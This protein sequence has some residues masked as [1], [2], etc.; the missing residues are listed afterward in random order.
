MAGEEY[1]ET[2]ETLNDTARGGDEYV[3]S[4]WRKRREKTIELKNIVSL[5]YELPLSSERGEKRIEVIIT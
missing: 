5:L 4:A 1:K 3:E 2:L